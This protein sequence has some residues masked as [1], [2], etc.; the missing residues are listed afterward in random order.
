LPDATS[1]GNSTPA[2]V[3]L[4][5]GAILSQIYEPV[6][7][8]AYPRLC[9]LGMAARS[10]SEIAFS[11][12]INDAAHFRCAFRGRFACSARELRSGGAAG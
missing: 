5:S 1:F 8:A 9:D 3:S 6:L 10:V 11:W 4:R 2:F 7:Y 12:G